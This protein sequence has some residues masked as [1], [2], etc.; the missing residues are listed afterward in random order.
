L[1]GIGVLLFGIFYW[2]VWRIIL[3]KLGKYELVP[4]KETLEDGT[5]VTIVRVDLNVFKA[6]LMFSL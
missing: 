2:A 4:V 6:P 1:A 5:V 3:P